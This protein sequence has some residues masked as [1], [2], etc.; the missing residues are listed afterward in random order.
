MDMGLATSTV[1]KLWVAEIYSKRCWQSEIDGLRSRRLTET[2]Q[3]YA[4]LD[5]IGPHVLFGLLGPLTQ[6]SY[7]VRLRRAN[8]VAQSERI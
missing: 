1:Q 8:I 2:I 6:V 4:P 5:A 3:H 7:V